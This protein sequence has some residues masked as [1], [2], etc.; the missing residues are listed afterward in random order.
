MKRLKSLTLAIGLGSAVALTAI[1]GAAPRAAAE[2]TFRVGVR[3]D[4]LSMDPIASSDNPSIWAQLLIYDT[5]IRPSPDGTNLE[6]GLAEK[7]TVAPDGKEYVFTLRAAKFADGSPVTADDVIFSLKRAAGEKSDWARFFKPIT[8]YEA[9][10]PHT[11]KMTLDKPFTPM[12]NNLAL[13]SGAILPKALVEKD[14]AAFFAHPI[15]SGP[16]VLKAWNKGDKIVLAKNP[17][18]WQA[19]R[20]AID[21]AEIQVIGEDNS[22]VLK[23][24]AAEIDAAIDI[25][26]NQLK[27]LQS[28]PDIKTAAADVFRVEMVQLNTTK[29]PFDDVRVRRALNYAVDKEAIIKGVLFGNAKPAVSSIPVM[30]YH[31]TDSRI[32]P[33]PVSCIS[34]TR[35]SLLHG[36]CK[37]PSGPRPAAWRPGRSWGCATAISC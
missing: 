9:V 28:L 26:F 36:F 35:G 25:P 18:Y 1:L 23:L 15:G 5:L 29:K 19:G 22:R 8:R 34:A 4:A 20:P 14:P 31:N 6:P 24:R 21:G 10:D 2:T 32:L 16:F 12:L 30:R 27:Q 11:I 13:F 17:L 37:K 7:W 3:E 33:A